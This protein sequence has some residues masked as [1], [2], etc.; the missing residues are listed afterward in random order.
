MEKYGWKKLIL[1]G[2][3]DIKKVSSFNERWHSSSPWTFVIYVFGILLLTKVIIHHEYSY[4]QG[5][6]H[7]AS[8]RVRLNCMHCSQKHNFKRHSLTARREIDKL[9][10]FSIW[11]WRNGCKQLTSSVLTPIMPDDRRTIQKRNASGITILRA[12]PTKP[13]LQTKTTN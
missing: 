2:C 8:Q 6:M 5:S 11:Q 4:R 3:G 9:G 7:L 13:A 12:E 1:E 10:W